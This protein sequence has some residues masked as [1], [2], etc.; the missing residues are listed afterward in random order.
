LSVGIIFSNGQETSWFLN[1]F[2]FIADDDF[3]IGLTSLADTVSV[4]F[5]SLSGHASFPWEWVGGI[6]DG[7]SLIHFNL[8][9]IEA[10]ENKFFNLNVSFDGVVVHFNTDVEA[11][12]DLVGG[13]FDFGLA[14]NFSVDVG[15]SLDEFIEWASAIFLGLFIFSNE[16]EVRKSLIDEFGD[17]EFE[18]VFSD[19]F[20]S[21]HF[22]VVVIGTIEF[23][24]EFGWESSVNSEFIFSSDELFFVDGL[25][26]TLWL[27]EIGSFYEL[28]I[29][30]FD[31]VWETIILPLG[32]EGSAIVFSGFVNE[33]G[34]DVD[35]I[36]TVVGIAAAGWH[37][38]S[39]KLRFQV[40]DSIFF[41]NAGFDFVVGEIENVFKIAEIRV[42]RVSIDGLTREGLDTGGFESSIA[43]AFSI[44]EGGI[45]S[46]RGTDVNVV[47]A[48]IAVDTTGLGF[49]NES[50]E[51][52]WGRV[53][54]N[55]NI[56]LRFFEGGGLIC[57]QESLS[58]LL[59]GKNLSRG[60]TDGD[61]DVI[62]SEGTSTIDGNGTIDGFSG[63]N[64]FRVVV[65]DLFLHGEWTDEV[66]SINVGV[67][68]L[69][70]V[71]S[72]GEIET[73]KALLDK[74]SLL[75][76]SGGDCDLSRG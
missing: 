3:K 13:F 26:G 63:N 33:A 25:D 28:W 34:L 37:F 70:S 30:H 16:D 10:F 21:A 45:F 76:K 64:K 12:S 41:D 49:K 24:V 52:P 19:E 73:K 44:D 42:D 54:L 39:G 18:S 46:A 61:L 38:E 5:D 40:K 50:S 32:G 69:I 74:I 31:S 57:D 65:D 35:H 27:G 48:I 1:S 14:T 55:F 71:G 59:N 20:S 2:W 51:W 47:W 6:N 23:I 4:K 53:N 22:I 58:F 11:T 36:T 8:F 62:F 75:M 29:G 60:T 9:V 56:D 7:L 17:S 67:K 43:H 72:V 66:K 68:E 15:G